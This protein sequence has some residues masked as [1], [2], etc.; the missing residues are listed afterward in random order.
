[1]KKWTFLK[2]FCQTRWG[3]RFKNREELERY[4]EQELQKYQ[5]FLLQHSPYFAQGVP[6]DFRYMDKTFMMEHFNELNTQGIDRDQALE[7]AIRGEQ[8][9]DFTEMQGEVAVV[10]PLVPPPPRHFY[11]HRNRT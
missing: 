2:T 4:Q 3:H 11:H 1:M 9:R 5:A 10:F 6:K 7:M 8:S